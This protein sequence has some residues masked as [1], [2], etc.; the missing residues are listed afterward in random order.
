[1]A[2]LGK[3]LEEGAEHLY[4]RDLAQR[5]DS[6]KADVL[7][8]VE[9]IRRTEMAL[10][11][12]FTQGKLIDGA[13]SFVM[14]SLA[15]TLSGR[16]KQPLAVG[17]RAASEALDRAAPFGEVRV[18]VGPGGVPDD[19]KVI[20]LSQMARERDKPESEIVA[21]LEAQ[22]YRLMTPEIF[23]SLLERMK[24]RLLTR[25]IALPATRAALLP[26]QASDDSEGPV[27]R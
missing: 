22:G 25:V 4:R 18:A 17:A 9:D 8:E 23:S 19:V 16:H 11:S 12:D 3:A 10:A 24:R 6:L 14:V 13:L 2:A 5:L 7:R 20:T 27:S 1:M 15:A 26:E 21:A